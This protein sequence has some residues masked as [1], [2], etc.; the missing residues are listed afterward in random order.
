M[1][2]WEFAVRSEIISDYAADRKADAYEKMNEL[3][4]KKKG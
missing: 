1:E 2:D 3:I 4:L